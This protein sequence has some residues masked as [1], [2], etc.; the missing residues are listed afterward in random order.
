MFTTPE[1]HKREA[2]IRP[3]SPLL[4][5]PGVAADTNS[6]QDL[7]GGK[8]LLLQLK[9]NWMDSASEAVKL[10]CF[11]D[12]YLICKQVTTGNGGSK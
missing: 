5:P 10:L 12:V 7:A 1:E 8:F 2:V 6:L 9:C 3:E 11:R 4:S